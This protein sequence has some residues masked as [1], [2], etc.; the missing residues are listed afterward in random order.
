MSNADALS[1][2][3]NQMA[4]AVERVAKSIVTVFGRDRQSATGIVYANELVLTADHVLERDD[5]LSVATADG[6]KLAAQLIGRDPTTDLAV[7]RVAGLSA[8]SAAASA[9]PRVGQWVLAVG[10]PEEGLMASHGVVSAVGGPLRMGNG[11]NVERYIRTD[12]TPYPGFSGGPLT[13]ATGAVL[14]ILT[15]GLARNVAIGIPFDLALRVAQ[16]LTSQ[17]YVKRGYL[18]VIS[19]QVKLPTSQRAG[20]SQEHGLLVM[21]VEDDSPAEKGG[22]LMGDILTSVDGHVVTN[23]DELMGLLSGDR[24]GRAVNLG[25]VRG[26]TL[27]TV[28]VVVGQRK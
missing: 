16:T 10:Q 2:L 19:Q 15:T 6:K 14:G 9:A 20:L 3:S 27:Q 13:D 24:V 22:M 23:A 17:G 18:G 25:V 7:L 4:D 8:P 26:G 12:A 11:V 5:N 1:A 28:S 21:R